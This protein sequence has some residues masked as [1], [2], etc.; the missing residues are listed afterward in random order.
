MIISVGKVKNHPVLRSI[1][2]NT[3]MNVNKIY[4]SSLF[5]MNKGN[6]IETYSFEKDSWD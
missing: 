2:K 6:I 4:V 3:Q 5:N 1:I